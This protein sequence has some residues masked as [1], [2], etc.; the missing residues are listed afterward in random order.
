[1]ETAGAA[2]LLFFP[3]CIWSHFI[4]VLP[5]PVCI[6]SPLRLRALEIFP[7]LSRVGNGLCSSCL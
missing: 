5:S 7:P 1:M 6:I 2:S 3:G 4:L